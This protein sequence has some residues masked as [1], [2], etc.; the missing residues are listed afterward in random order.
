MNFLKDIRPLLDNEDPIDFYKAVLN[1]TEYYISAEI[2]KYLYE[3]YKEK[4]SKK[5]IDSF[6]ELNKIYKDKIEPNL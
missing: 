5:Y 3:K 2:K 1:D 6:N 4:Y